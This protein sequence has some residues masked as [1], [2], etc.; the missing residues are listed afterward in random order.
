MSVL[1][2]HHTRLVLI[3]LSTLVLGACGSKSLL[4]QST[5]T[6]LQE[7]ITSWPAALPVDH[8]Q[9]WEKLSA[10]GYVMPADNTY[11]DDKAASAIN[12]LSE[13]VPG[14]AYETAL[15]NTSELGE[16]LR[17]T[18]GAA[19]SSTLSCATYRL[20]LGGVQPGVVSADVNLRSRS[21]D[22]PSAYWL[23][24]S[25]YSTG[26]WQWHGPFGDSH[27]RISTTEPGK[28]YLS[29]LG[30]LFVCVLAHNGAAVDVVGIG[31]NARETGDTTPPSA[32]TGLVAMPYAGALMLEW[33]HVAADDLAGY[34][35]C[36]AKQSFSNPDAWYVQREPYLEGADWHMLATTP[37][38][39]YVCV[40][41]VDLSGNE[42]AASDVVSACPLA[43]APP[44]VQ[45]T[46]DI[47]SGMR[48]TQ[49]TLTAT[50]AEL[51]DWDLNGDGLV[52]VTGDTTGTAS[53]TYDAMG[54]WRPLV[55]GVSSD[56]TKAACAAVSIII[57]GNT[58]PVASATA[59]PQSGIA[60]LSVT[61]SGTAEDDEDEPAE[62]T[63]AWDFDGDGAYEADTNTLTPAAQEYSTA[64][65]YNAKFRVEDSEGAWDVDT[66]AVQV[67]PAPDPANVPPTADVQADPLSGD[68]PVQVSFDASASS[69]LDGSIVEYAWDWDGNG[70]YDAITDTPTAS[71]TYTAAGS[72]EVKVRV[73]DDDGARAT[74]TVTI[75]VNIVGNTAPTA[76]LTATPSTGDTPL[77]VT[78]DA[79]GS[80]DP[81]GTIVKYEWDFD[82]N[83]TYDS[84]GG[85][86]ST[87]YTYSS[88]G[89]YT[90][91]V[92]VTDDAGAQDTD[93]ALVD[94]NVP[95]NDPPVAALSVSPEYGD[96]G[97]T[98]TL[99]ASGS[100]DPDGSIVK[101]EWDFNGNGAYGAYGAVA[102]T[103]HVYNNAGIFAAKV[104]VTDDAGAQDT[105]TAS[106]RVN[107]VLPG[108]ST[109]W[110]FGRDLRHNRRSPFIGAQT[111]NTRW[112]Y[113]T[114]NNVWSSPAI[115]ADGTIY[116]GNMYL[117]Q[118]HAVNPDGSN[119]WTYT[120]G[121]SIESSPAIGADGTIYV[122]SHDNKL[123]AI[124]PSGSMKWT[125]TTGHDVVSSPAIGPDGIIYVG[126]LDYNLYAVYP[127]GTL[128]WTY[129]T[130]ERIYYS[131]PAI[132]PDG[133]IYVGSVDHKL[134]AVNPDGTQ[135]WTYTTS[136]HNVTSSPAIGPDGTVY[137]GSWDKKLYAI[138]PDGSFR[139]SYSTDHDIQSSPAIDSDGTIYVGS[140]DDKLHAVN[141]DGSQKWTFTTSDNVISSPAIGADGTIYVGSR[142]FKIYAINP[143]GSQKWHRT[144][145]NYVFSS[146]AIGPDGTVYVGSWDGKLYA[147]GP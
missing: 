15:G 48:G 86:S 47:L 21:D 97:L 23:G 4:I 137:V 65:L 55:K 130:G 88:A 87:G 134:H 142:D 128:K 7:S 59:D 100:T 93:T 101:Y 76:D 60:P 132:G 129:A 3:I 106:I 131:S 74:D 107:E 109:W 118:L 84:Y 83:G 28:D 63:Y 95:G 8:V 123:H 35:L 105:A 54:L 143:D 80:A 26:C 29:P 14:V 39:T 136:N 61:F 6:A 89:D 99:D 1:N 10:L 20:T 71:Y 77:M 144:T 66:V 102:T 13:F 25:N 114:G 64:G 145:G 34:N 37:E 108:V 38:R 27:V 119:K 12:A 43:D 147:I 111:N 18:S 9:P 44:V 56:G 52:D 135:K 36:W 11:F 124:K 126:S 79:S 104:R 30:N 33:H 91:K 82:G 5:E 103:L 140:L 116:I 146:P 57:T 133:T 58:R 75:T 72:P 94:V 78:L 127:D 46:T 50:G 62:L 67:L 115:G 42:S 40:T 98:V 120:A 19:G 53:Q 113:S 41:A 32:P 139:W 45:V 73:E 117:N 112:S 70:Q 17:L 138:N 31:A 110:M 16:G 22:S 90:A 68:A 24:L 69:D 125:Y 2:I 49:V 85:S 51:Y 121:G 96:Q 92:R 81:D 141:P 122:G